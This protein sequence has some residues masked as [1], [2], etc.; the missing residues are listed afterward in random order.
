M[1]K[2]IILWVYEYDFLID[3]NN[4]MTRAHEKYGVFA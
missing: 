1:I 3:L 2:L 4:N